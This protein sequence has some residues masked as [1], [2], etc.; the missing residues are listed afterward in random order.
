MPDPRGAGLHLAFQFSYVR[1]DGR[2]DG[3]VEGDSF[4]SLDQILVPTHSLGDK[5]TKGQRD[6]GTNDP[7]SWDKKNHPTSRD[8]KKS[9]NLLGQKKSPCFVRQNQQKKN[10]FFAWRYLTIVYGVHQGIIN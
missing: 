1:T 5:R 7:T 2:R 9:P 8:K 4:F 10:F 6:K 3:R